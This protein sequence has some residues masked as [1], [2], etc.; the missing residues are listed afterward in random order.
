MCTVKTNVLHIPLSTRVGNV[1]SKNHKLHTYQPFYFI[2]KIVKRWRFLWMRCI[3]F[4]KTRSSMIVM[5]HL[6]TVTI[7]FL[8]TKFVPFGSC[9]AV[10]N[11]KACV[12]YRVNSYFKCFLVQFDCKFRIQNLNN[13]KQWPAV[14]T[15]FGATK[16]SKSIFS[17]LFYNKY[18]I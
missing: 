11:W 14:S 2:P 17:W 5:D 15:K 7:S 18:I 1:K 4:S 10:Q 9:D 13:L 12:S 6:K 3:S 8:N 16:L